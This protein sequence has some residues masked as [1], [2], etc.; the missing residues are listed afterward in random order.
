MPVVTALWV[1][2]LRNSVALKGFSLTLRS[3]EGSIVHHPSSMGRMGDFSILAPGDEARQMLL[4]P[5]DHQQCMLK[6]N[7]PFPDTLSSI[8][9]I[10]AMKEGQEIPMAMLPLPARPVILFSKFPHPKSSDFY[11]KIKTSPQCQA[12]FHSFFNI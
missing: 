9:V 1:S 5:P 8:K 4:R 12:G 2:L 11:L 10:S 6:A 7:S 3:G